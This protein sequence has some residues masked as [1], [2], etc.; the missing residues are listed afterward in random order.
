MSTAGKSSKK[1][2]K[3]ATATFTEIDNHYQIT[4]TCEIKAGIAKL[5]R[6]VII[7]SFRLRK[8]MT[9]STGLDFK[10]FRVFSKSRHQGRLD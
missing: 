5:N 4:R 6:A 7:E 9:S 10:F 2:T 3:T 1:A 8:R